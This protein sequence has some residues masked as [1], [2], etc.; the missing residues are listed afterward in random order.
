[1]DEQFGISDMSSDGTVTI[2]SNLTV[3]VNGETKMI[4][5][6]QWRVA[7]IKNQTEIQ[8]RNGQNKALSDLLPNNLYNAIIAFWT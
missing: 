1:M 5:G 7:L 2:F 8:D 4:Q 3:T 6:T